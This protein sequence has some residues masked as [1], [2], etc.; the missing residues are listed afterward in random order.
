MT[1]ALLTAKD[2]AKHFAVSQETVRRWEREGQLKG[3]RVVGSLRFTEEA[4][5]EFIAR[6]Q[7]ERQETA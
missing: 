5:K 4:V 2:V 6:S 7:A 1:S 3:I